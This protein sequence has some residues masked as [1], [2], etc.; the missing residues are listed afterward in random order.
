MLFYGTHALSEDTRACVYLSQHLDGSL[1]TLT[2]FGGRGRNGNGNKTRD[3][4]VSFRENEVGQKDSR[5][6]SLFLFQVSQHRIFGSEPTVINQPY[7][8][9]RGII[10]SRP[11]NHRLDPIELIHRLSCAKSSK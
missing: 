7:G 8:S 11:N 10:V 6:I 9:I 1:T 3:A 4:G 2:F 5:D